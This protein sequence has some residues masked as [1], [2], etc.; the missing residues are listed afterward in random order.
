MQ[1]LVYTSI[2][3][4]ELCSA[5][6]SIN[7]ITRMSERFR[8]AEAAA[9]PSDPL[10]VIHWKDAAGREGHGNPITL[11][12]VAAVEG[13]DAVTPESTWTNSS[14]FHWLVKA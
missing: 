8:I 13:F 10:Y 7:E 6:E 3:T 14:G 4:G 1:D 12:L 2:H 5:K 9:K 11:L